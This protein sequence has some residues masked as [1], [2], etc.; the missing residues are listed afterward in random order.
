MEVHMTLFLIIAMSIMLA[1]SCSP[2]TAETKPATDDYIEISSYDSS[3]TSANSYAVTGQSR[4]RMSNLEEGGLYGVFS[5]S[6]DSSTSRSVGSAPNLVQVGT[7]NYIHY[8]ADASDQV[9]SGYDVGIWNT[10]RVNVIKYE[11]EGQDMKIDTS[12]DDFVF[13]DD[14]GNRVYQEYYRIN[15]LDPEYEDLDPSRI[16]VLNYGTGGGYE[17][18]VGIIDEMTGYV[19]NTGIF[20]FTGKTAL[21]LLN[22]R[23]VTT[24]DG[25]EELM[26][27]NPQILEVGGEIRFK[28]PFIY[29]LIATEEELVLEL[30]LEHDYFDYQL[31]WGGTHGRVAEGSNAGARQPYIFPMSYD[32]ATNKVVLYIGPVKE[33]ALFT[34]TAE[35]RLGDDGRLEDAGSMILRPI[36]EQEKSVLNIINVSEHMEDPVEIRLPAGQMITPVIFI[37]DNPEDLLGLHVKGESESGFYARVM[38][39]NGRGYSPLDIDNMKT[40]ADYPNDLDNQSLEYLFVTRKWGYAKDEWLTLS[41]S[42]TGEFPDTDAGRD[43][44]S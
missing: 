28:T 21:S 34:I 19:K 23:Y 18:S 2:Q 25:T 14:R 38:Y 7:G 30:A 8:S 43:S 11:P 12:T 29:E 24:V 22:Q 42:K 20:D 26:L 41:F 13:I 5:R 39:T 1:V 4:I 17:H 15:L 6:Y 40:S 33:N 44:A 35:P 32:S 9:F 10:G 16:A 31:Q 27:V 36:T 3:V 37:A